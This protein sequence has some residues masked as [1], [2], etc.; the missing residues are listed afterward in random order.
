MIKNALLRNA[1]H[2]YISKTR[3]LAMPGALVLTCAGDVMMKQQIP[4]DLLNSKK[5]YLDSG[6]DQARAPAQEGGCLMSHQ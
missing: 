1:T 6:D 3:Q 4:S 2:I 5:L